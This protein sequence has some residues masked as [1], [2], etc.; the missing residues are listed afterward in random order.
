VNPRTVV[1]LARFSLVVAVA[2]ILFVA[3]TDRRIAFI[4]DIWDKSKHAGAFFVLALLVDVSH[5]TGRFGLAKIATLLAF[6][7]LI[8]AIQH[9][10]PHREASLLDLVADGAGI[11]LFACCI[12]L[13]A[14]FP[15]L[16]AAR[17]SVVSTVV[18]G[19]SPP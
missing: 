13:L 18:P 2:L 10:L 4:D 12:P 16:N 9:F 11:A 14:R 8:E 19:A 15:V 6:G 5:P 3:T 1:A 7:V 17:G